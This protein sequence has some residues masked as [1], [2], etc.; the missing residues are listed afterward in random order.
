MEEK[1]RMGKTILK[2][3]LLEQDVQ[4]LYENVWDN[5]LISQNNELENVYIKRKN[6]KNYIG[7]TIQLSGVMPMVNIAKNMEWW[8]ENASWINNARNGSENKDENYCI[9]CI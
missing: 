3:E 4:L 7:N 8:C 1:Q 5:R 6:K 9:M 2:L